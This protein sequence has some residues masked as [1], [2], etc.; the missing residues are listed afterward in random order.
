[1]YYTLALV[2]SEDYVDNDWNDGVVMFSWWDS[3]TV[4]SVERAE[5]LSQE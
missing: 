2:I 1:M 5:Q 4:R 3:P